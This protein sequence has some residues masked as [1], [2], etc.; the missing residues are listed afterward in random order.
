MFIREEK[1][2]A[3]F[4]QQ[5]QNVNYQYNAA[6]DINFNLIHNKYDVA[7]TLQKLQAEVEKAV[8]A[9]AIDEEVAI[10]VESK[11]KKASI[12]VEKPEP[13][14]KVVLDYLSEAKA[15]IEGIASMAGLVQGLAHTVEVIRRLF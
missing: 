15:L 10:D 14:K 8:K 1:T 9:G 2:M 5:N 12:Q 3:T 11:I 6:G 13:D 4:N 7:A